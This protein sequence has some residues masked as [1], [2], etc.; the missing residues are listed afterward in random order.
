MKTY[1]E[2]DLLVQVRCATPEQAEIMAEFTD[3]LNQASQ[4]GG[5]KRARGEKVDWRVDP[6]HTQAMYRH[7]Q[8]WE[9]GQEADLDSGTHPL[10][11]LAWRALAVAWQETN[12]AEQRAGFD[13][14]VGDGE[15]D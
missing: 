1:S 2:D 6:G 8:R 12:E 14:S 11:H 7:L 13:M 10:V 4:D 3:L 9:D 15:E 5:R